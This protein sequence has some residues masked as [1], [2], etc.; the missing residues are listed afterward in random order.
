MKAMFS[1]GGLKAPGEDG[2]LANFHQKNRDI[3]GDSVCNFVKNITRVQSLREVNK[4]LI[5]LIPKN[6]KPKFANQFR[7]ISLCNMLYKCI[8]KLLVRRFK[9]LLPQLPSPLQASFVLGRYIQDNIV[10]AQE[11]I[12][13]VRKIKGRRGFVAI[14]I[15]LEKAYNRMN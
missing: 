1:I 2:F 11:M 8:S 13:S 14:K 10:I 6:D 15:G 3:V 9:H 4:T 12:H 7:H 5:C